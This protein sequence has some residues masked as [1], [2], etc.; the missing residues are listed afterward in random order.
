MD[1]L[2]WCLYGHLPCSKGCPGT[3]ENFVVLPHGRSH[4]ADSGQNLLGKSD[5]QTTEYA[6]DALGA[7]GG[8]VRLDGHTQLDDAPAQH[9]H[10]DGLNARKNEVAEVVDNGKGI[11][12]GGQGRAGQGGAQGQHED[13]GEIEAVAPSGPPLRKGIRL[14]VFL[15]QHENQPFLFQNFDVVQTLKR[16]GQVGLGVSQ[17]GVVNVGRCPAVLRQFD[18]GVLENVILLVHHRA[19]PPDEQ[20]GVVVVQGPHLVGSHQLFATMSSDEF[21]NGQKNNPPR[22][23]EGVVASIL[24]K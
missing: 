6:E 18:I 17:S 24:K 12:V 11:G 3:G 4:H 21:K 16:H 7:L 19:F 10:A 14:G 13:G 1:L 8:V 9:D 15:V 5:E 23:R 22:L 2:V 20:Q